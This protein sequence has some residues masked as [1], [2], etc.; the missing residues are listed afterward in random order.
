MFSYPILHC[1]VELPHNSKIIFIKGGTID[2]L[3]N[4]EFETLNFDPTKLKINQTSNLEQSY[5]KIIS[6]GKFMINL[7]F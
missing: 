1:L 6:P 5:G 4:E 3:P 7:F 2:K